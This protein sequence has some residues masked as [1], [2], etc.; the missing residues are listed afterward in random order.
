L[1]KG[2]RPK[3]QVEVAQEEDAQAPEA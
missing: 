1:E 2:Q 3:E